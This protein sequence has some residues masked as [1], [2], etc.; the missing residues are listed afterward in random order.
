[1]PTKTLKTCD[2]CGE[3]VSGEPYKYSL[4]IKKITYTITIPTLAERYGPVPSVSEPV[5]EMAD[6]FLCSLCIKRIVVAENLEVS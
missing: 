6:D 2:I 3:L 4:K 1:M 5:G